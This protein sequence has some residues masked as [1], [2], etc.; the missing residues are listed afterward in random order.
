MNLPPEVV[1]DMIAR[2]ATFGPVAKLGGPEEL[3]ER[4]K[5]ELIEGG[6]A[7]VDGTLVILVPVATVSE[8]NGREW[9]KRSN[10]TKRARKA[11][12]DVLGPRLGLLAPFA[13][14]F[15]AG[16]ALRVVLTRLGGRKVDRT[17]LPGCVKAVEDH[18]SRA[19]LADDGDPRWW[20]EYAQEPGVG[21]V[22]VRIEITENLS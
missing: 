14:A 7:L 15:H 6:I 17:N 16:I 8:S 13:E 10:R 22:G 11:L 4:C 1:R 2:G 12:A 21:P 18:L 3:L 19:M 5:P 9:R 20:V